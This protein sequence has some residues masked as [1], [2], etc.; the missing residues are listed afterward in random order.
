MRQL[1]DRGQVVGDPGH[2]MSRLFAV[3]IAERKFLQMREQV[4]AHVRFHPDPQHMPVAD[5][6]V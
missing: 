5:V 2:D 1:C 3:E 6:E 4:V